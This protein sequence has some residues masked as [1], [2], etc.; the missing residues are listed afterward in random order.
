[1]LTVPAGIL[2]RSVVYFRACGRGR[3]ECVV[4]WLGQLDEPGKIDQVIHPVHSAS[5]AGFDVDGPWLNDL[6]LRLARDRREL[7]AQ[8][9]THP[10]TAYHSSRDDAMAAL[11]TEGFLSLV[12]PDFA[13][14]DQPLGGAHLAERTVDGGWR[15]VDPIARI[16][17]S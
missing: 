12:V 11:Q 8:V 9:H 16:S 13:L 4:Y 15:A 10:G 17:I 6:W 14:R 2:E 7:R 3:A 5:A 1:M